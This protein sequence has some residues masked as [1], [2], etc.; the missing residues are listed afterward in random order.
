MEPIKNLDYYA[1]H[2]A[3]LTVFLLRNLYTYPW[4]D[5][6]YCSQIW[7]PYQAKDIKLLEDVQHRATNSSIVNDYKPSEVALLCNR[8]QIDSA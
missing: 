2:S 8:P 1:G 6:V 7:R 5:L 4:S 3:Q